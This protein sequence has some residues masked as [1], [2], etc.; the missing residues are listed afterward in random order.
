MDRLINI[1]NNDYQN[2]FNYNNEHLFFKNIIWWNSMKTNYFE[3][4]QKYK[5][6]IPYDTSID[7]SSI[8]N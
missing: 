6:I 7:L 2:I 5:E 4:M 1:I 8:I 3:F